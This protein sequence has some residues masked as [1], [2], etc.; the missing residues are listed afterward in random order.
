MKKLKKDIVGF[1]TTGIIFGV[2]S[3]I[4]SEQGVASP[5]SAISNKM[6]MMGNIIGA[7][8]VLRQVKKLKVK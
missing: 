3:Q 6:P 2:G 1:A 8:V 4:A 5:Y 7:S